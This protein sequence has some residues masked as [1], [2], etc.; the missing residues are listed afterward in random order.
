MAGAWLVIVAG[1][2]RQH[3]GNDGYDDE[4]SGHYSWD[5]T[6]AN[7]TSLEPGDRIVLWNKKMLLGAS[8]IEQIATGRGR[9]PLYKC[10]VC[11]KADLKA[12]KKKK[13][14]YRC[15]C[16]SEFDEPEIEL[17]EVVTYR[18]RHDAGW[19]DLYGKLDG[20]TLRRLCTSPKSQQSM[21]PLRWDAFITALEEP[22]IRETLS[23]L[24][25]RESRIAG[26]HRRAT[27]RLRL[28]QAAFRRK[29]LAEQGSVCAF[30]GPCPD[31]ALQ[32]AHL[33]SYADLGIHHSSGGLLMRSDI[34]VLFDEGLLAVDP[35]SACIDVGPSLRRYDVYGHLH[36][37]GLHIPLTRGQR[38]WLH[39]HWKQHRA[40]AWVASDSLR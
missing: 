26:G 9:K 37:N 25:V 32:A 1:D 21:R 17:C 20:P 14:I 34:H 8:I 19:V 39:L 24:R 10:P 12:R 2:D 35:V 3:G 30:V 4:P 36:G 22:N 23:P 27:V 38:E 18:S 31:A 7:A 16:E 29:L 33:Y 40:A 15:G 28:G 6:V 13:P 5:S 11:G